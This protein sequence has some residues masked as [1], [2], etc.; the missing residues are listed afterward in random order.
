MN[1]S[2]LLG[3]PTFVYLSNSEEASSHPDKCYVENTLRIEVP[4][5]SYF[6]NEINNIMGKIHI[7]ETPE[8][9]LKIKDVIEKLKMI[10]TPEYR[11]KVDRDTFELNRTK[12]TVIFRHLLMLKEKNNTC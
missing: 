1:L 10:E 2:G 5:E 8:Y 12:Y 6:N 9:K 11:A 3:F 4:N 7:I